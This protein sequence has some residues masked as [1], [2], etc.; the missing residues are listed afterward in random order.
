MRLEWELQG[1]LEM[2][3]VS[4][5]LFGVLS[6]ALRK[7]IAWQGRFLRD[8]GLMVFLEARRFAEGY[9]QPRCYGLKRMRDFLAGIGPSWVLASS[10]DIRSLPRHISTII[11]FKFWALIIIL[12]T[13]FPCKYLAILSIWNQAPQGQIINHILDLL[14]LIFNA[15]TPPP[16]RVILEVQQLEA[17]E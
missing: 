13:S 14:D 12:S 16:Q 4:Q 3:G 11:S 8:S 10:F 5:R 6:K 17:S 15:I 1:R 7:A 9:P 2:V